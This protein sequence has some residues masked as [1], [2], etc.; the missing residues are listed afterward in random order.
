MVMAKDL[1][2]FTL[3]D[4]KSWKTF[5]T[6]LHQ[7][8]DPSILAYTRIAFGLLMIID[9][10]QER[11]MT[12][13]D[14]NY[15][16]DG[17][18][19][20]RFPFFSFLKPLPADFMI[21][22]YFFMFLGALG[23]MLGCCYRLSCLVFTL[24]YWYFFLLD[25]ST[26][27]NH[28]YLYGLLGFLFLVTDCHRY[29]SVDGL[30][31]K[32]LRDSHVPLWNYALFR[33][34]IF[35]V[36]FYAG[37]K[38]TNFDW[39]SGYSM[40]RLSR[41]WVF[42]PMRIF[43]DDANMDFIIVHLGGF[44]LDISAGFLLFFDR[45]RYIG[46][47]LCGMFHAM[48]SQLFNIGMFPYAMIA[49]MFS[50][51]PHNSFKVMMS[52][53]PGNHHTSPAQKNENCIYEDSTKKKTKIINISWKQSFAAIF[54]SLYII[55]QLFLPYS[56]FVTKGYN[57]W[58]EGPYGY[59][60]DMMIHSFQNQHTKIRYVDGFGEEGYL[61][62]GAFL[63]AGRRRWSAHPDMTVQY[64]RCLKDRLAG[65]GIENA[66]IYFDIWK[67]MNGRF[68]Q[69]VVDP[70]VDVASYDWSPFKTATFVLPVLT[71]LSNW[72]EKLKSIRSEHKNQTLSVVFVADFP[73]MELENFVHEDFKNTTVEVLKGRISV[74]LDSDKSNLTLSE[75][76]RF[77]VPGGDYHVIRTTSSSTSCYV[78]VYHNSTDVEI[79]G[80]VEEYRKRISQSEN[81]F[82]LTQSMADDEDQMIV[83]LY[84]REEAKKNSRKI[85]F[86]N[87]S[88]RF[89]LKKCAIFRRSFLLSI[90]SVRNILFGRPNQQQLSL[91]VEHLD[92]WFSQTYA[93][94]KPAKEESAKPSDRENLKTE[95]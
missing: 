11:G 23:I 22:L 17:E 28:S 56:H 69:R 20:C 50:F 5:A 34:Q 55:E 72:R 78:Y 95:L 46:F 47:L 59:S 42:D 2:G 87:R 74:H 88:V 3:N 51:C 63:N 43:L 33:F 86:Y 40:H 53:L 35:L 24:V 44:T 81:D 89:V 37:L 77:K 27:N 90:Y 82:W 94:F 9:I 38:K 57:G 84:L 15:G 4:F 39:L 45:T 49:T 67:S 16:E 92:R 32:E 8:R 73:G 52:R 64:A 65:I 18:E 71:E 10:P 91:E 36:Y 19:F 85:S 30:L 7:A 70:R 61:K 75:G 21:L 13:A 26:W 58:T 1:F 62:P 12:S 29:A 14:I 31:R 80:K 93:R 68:Q 79:H 60:W 41:H 48:N 54:T 83:E 76:K 6:L 25:K 66:S